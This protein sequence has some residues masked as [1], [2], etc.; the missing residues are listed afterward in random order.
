MGT[1]YGN[2]VDFQTSKDVPTIN[3]INVTSIM[4]VS[5]I[6]GGVITSNGGGSVS[7]KGVCWSMT[8]NPTIALTNKT[9]D[10]SGGESFESS[11][12]N[13]TP[14]T[15]YYLRAYATN[16]IGTSYGNQVS[17]STPIGL[18]YVGTS[19]GTNITHTSVI[20]GGSV[21][22]AGGGVISE[23]GLCWSKAPNPTISFGTKIID[24]ETGIGNF[25]I[26]IT[27][28]ESFGTGY[29][30]RAF[31]T[32][33]AGTSYGTEVY[34]ETMGL[35][36]YDG[37]TYESIVIADLEW[38][39]QNLNV[40]HY[41]NGDVIP[42]VSDAGEW[43]SLTTGAWCYYANDTANGIVYG[44]LYNWYALKD[45]RGLA[46]QGWHISRSDEFSYLTYSYLGGLDIAGGKMK[47]VGISHWNT[48]NTGATNS[49]G[50][51]GLPGG[52]RLAD[53]SF[54]S[55]GAY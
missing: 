20:S 39:Q 16:E 24:S 55:K 15:T 51:T 14:L 30:V 11:I 18:P 26:T 17:F 1:S 38:M 41:R 52:Y 46:P 47:E 19:T 31:A 6:S 22:N 42:Q 54:T 53:G 44:K 4:G 34:F 25:Q 23:R 8:P 10:G 29:Y 13:L 36:D 33:E 40:E 12:T 35:T 3:T 32:N 43:G 7:Q 9:T 27:G 2:Q 49:S 5:A 48:P 28:L 50:F 45:S 21:V 37:N